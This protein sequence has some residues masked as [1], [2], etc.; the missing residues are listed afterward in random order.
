[1]PPKEGSSFFR[2][3]DNYSTGF[4]CS[5]LVL[6][7][8]HSGV[9]RDGVVASYNA[10]GAL[11]IHTVRGHYVIIISIMIFENPETVI[12]RGS[13]NSLHD[14]LV[15]TPGFVPFN[16]DEP[17]AFSTVITLVS[18]P[19]VMSSVGLHKCGR[20]FPV[21]IASSIFGID[22]YTF[23]FDSGS[24]VFQGSCNIDAIVGQKPWS[25]RGKLV[26]LCWCCLAYVV[27]VVKSEAYGE[28]I[29][30]GFIGREGNSLHLGSVVVNGVGFVSNVNSSV[31]EYGEVST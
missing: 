4:R 19:T 25:S 12:G 20:D 23:S 31:E 11:S 15:D 27:A 26:D 18:E 3:S 13:S 17:R 1:M 28:E 22:V 8:L 6:V 2:K 21:H 24:S 5:S 7:C 9:A 29:F 14:L 10:D 16:D 30:D